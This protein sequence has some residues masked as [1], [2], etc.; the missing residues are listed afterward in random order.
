MTD[1]PGTDA[2]GPD[3]RRGHPPQPVAAVRG[4]AQDAGRAAQPDGTY[5]GQRL[6]EIVALLHDPRI[7]SDASKRQGGRS[8]AGR[9]AAGLHRH[10]PARARQPAPRG[11]IVLRPAAPPR[12][13]G[14]P[15]A[16]DARDGQPPHRRLRRPQRGSTSSTTSPIRSRS[17]PS[18]GSARRAAR[19]RAEFHDWSGALIVALGPRDQ[20]ERSR[21][22]PGG[23]QAS[24][25]WPSTWPSWSRRTRKEPGDDMLSRAWPPPT[26]LRAHGP[27]HSTTRGCC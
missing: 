11:H 3:P 15:R 27:G 22:R 7:S 8:P 12:P 25:S 9:Y 1:A 19:G 18:A 20:P 6:R 4:A 17:A 13:G 2:D 24:R 21:R 10:R 16:V 5:V 14:E 23:A 26:A